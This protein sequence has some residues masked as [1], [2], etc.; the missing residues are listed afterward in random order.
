MLIGARHEEGDMTLAR[1]SGEAL[2]VLLAVLAMH[3]MPMLH[4]STHGVAGAHI[5]VTAQKGHADHPTLDPVGTAAASASAEIKGATHW[6][7]HAAMAMCMALITVASVLLV[8]RRLLSRQGVGTAP[9]I[10]LSRLGRHAS[11]APPWA[12]PSLEKL[13]ILRI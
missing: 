8:V 10:H 2:V 3:S 9:R 11:R 4:P 6:S 7:P 12:A 1:R 5:A 13:S